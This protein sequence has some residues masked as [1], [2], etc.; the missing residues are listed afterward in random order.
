MSLIRLSP[1]LIAARAPASLT[2]ALML[3]HAQLSGPAHS[4]RT[5]G[6]WWGERHPT[7]VT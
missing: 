1:T 4:L 2:G 5:L 6:L 3:A 7:R